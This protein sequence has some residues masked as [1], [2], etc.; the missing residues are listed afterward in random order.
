MPVTRVKLRGTCM[1]YATRERFGGLSLK[2]TGWTVSGFGPQNMGVVLVRIEGGMWRHRKA[3]VKAKLRHE[4]CV[5]I[6]Y[7]SILSW[8]ITPLG[9]SGLAQNI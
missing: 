7:A 2:T 4:G 1:E 5:A 8:T 9:S 3:C 6:G